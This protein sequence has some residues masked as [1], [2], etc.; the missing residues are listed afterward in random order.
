MLT[1][2]ADGFLEIEDG[3]VE[4]LLRSVST[5]TFPGGGEERFDVQ[6][7]LVLKRQEA[8]R[9]AQV[10]FYCRA[11]KRTLV[12]AVEP[13]DGEE[14]LAAGM[15]ELGRLG[16]QLKEV[17]LN[18]SA[19]LRQV[20]LRDIP[21]LRRPGAAEAGERELMPAAGAVMTLDLGD[22]DSA[23][24]KRTA[25]L[26]HQRERE[27]D[28]RLQVL[29]A[30]IE[31]RLQPAAAPAGS[32][33]PF[34]PGEVVPAGAEPVIPGAPGPAD[35]GGESL[36]EALLAAAERRIQELERELIEAE[37]SMARLLKGKQR[38]AE[39]ERRIGELSEALETATGRC[40]AQHREHQSLAAA[41]A[42]V[43]SDAE[44][45][46][47][48]AARRQAEQDAALADVT[49]R[50]RAAEAARLELKKELRAARKR[51]RALERE[52]PP[53]TAG[54]AGTG[55]EPVLRAQ[56][57]EL[58]GERDRERARGNALLLENRRQGEVL[59]AV[60]RE[61][62]ALA[63]RLAASEVELAQARL[64][65]QRLEH[66]RAAAETRRAALAAAAQPQADAG[67][68]AAGRLLPHQVRPEPRP[69]GLFHPDWELRG[70]PCRSAA[71][72]VQ[73]WESVYNV[74]LSLEGYPSQY[75][76]AF[77]VVINGGGGPRP[78]LLYSL[79]TSRHLLVCVP[80][81]PPQDEA[82]LGRL[83]G[84]AQQYLKKSGFE[85]ERIATAEVANT[86]GACFLGG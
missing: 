65:S 74:Q 23:I 7:Y 45:R 12:F 85:M 50:L 5:V 46:R 17:D 41:H 32:P 79:K 52:P 13:A 67:P 73:A 56:L 66:S 48:A 57:A 30:A 2:A 82:A 11:L 18:L 60:S 10:G 20:V 36:P 24:A 54:D 1:H 22:S 28:Q 77:L 71:E 86:L 38:L 83:L 75:C 19:A 21:V 4:V 81:Q 14:P 40:E 59:T 9:V 3:D 51:L 42:E 34:S 70:L 58:T 72:V 29:R 6:A 64:E 69:G 53:G 8:G 37:T 39:Q 68:P 16:F 47:Q 44:N 76:A 15:T 33:P 61:R 55:V 80:G 27:L 63:G 62:D 25:A 49:S 43:V 26:R 35:D 78:Y 84:K 31:A